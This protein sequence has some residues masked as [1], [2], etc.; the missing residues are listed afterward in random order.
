MRGLNER[1]SFFISGFS[2][3]PNPTKSSKP[4]SAT[5][6]TSPSRSHEG[7]IFSI[8]PSKPM[9]KNPTTMRLPFITFSPRMREDPCK[10]SFSAGFPSLS[11]E[12]SFFAF[13]CTVLFFE[14]LQSIQAKTQELKVA[15][16]ESNNAS[17]PSV[18]RE[19]TI[20]SLLPTSMPN[21]KSNSQMSQV[22][23][24]PC[25]RA[26]T[27]VCE[28]RAPVDSLRQRTPDRIPK[29]IN[30]MTINITSRQPY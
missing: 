29:K 26:T 10:P 30:R 28:M 24:L 19:R 12:V 11:A 8:P 13:S 17:T 14:T 23:I 22:T 20:I 25:H 9:T 2:P 16:E 5:K 4:Q 18:G 21:R 7:T 1:T 6:L 3:M 15:A 27:S